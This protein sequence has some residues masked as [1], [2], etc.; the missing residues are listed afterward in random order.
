[1]KDKIL[2]AK[3]V[4][5][6]FANNGEQVH[7]LTNVNM[8]IFEGD[9]TVIMGSSGSGKSTLLYALSGMDK[10]TA[11]QVI[12][13]SVDSGEI[14]ITTQKEKKMAD[15]RTKDFGFIFQQMHLVSNLT[16]MENVS[17]TGFL[18]KRKSSADTKKKASELLDRMGL[19][20][21]KNNLPSRVSGGEQ[22]RCAIARAVINSPRIL[23]ADEPTGALNRK[24]TREVLDLL[25]ELNQNGQSIVM[26]T[27]DIKAAL[28]GNRLLYLEDGDIV[29][30]LELSNYGEKDKEGNKLQSTKAREA[31]VNAWLESLDW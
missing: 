24:N 30:E 19:N 28:R 9:F 31:Q 22:Q 23:F 14:D 2:S 20:E 13:K 27:H 5:K 29:G 25:T 7:V 8:D 3:D 1:M 11:G 16:L 4:Q 21:V 26:V 10:A 6:T 17:V 12:Y 15:I 18:D